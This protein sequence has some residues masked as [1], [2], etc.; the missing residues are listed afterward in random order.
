MKP[1]FRCDL[2]KHEASI[3][4]IVSTRNVDKSKVSAKGNFSRDF[5][6]STEYCCRDCFL[7]YYKN[8]T[9]K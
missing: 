4:N 6:V 3:D 7:K 1:V 8:A 9:A 2:C 5:I